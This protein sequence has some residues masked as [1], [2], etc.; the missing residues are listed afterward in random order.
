MKI[1]QLNFGKIKGSYFLSIITEI[2]RNC[3]LMW[4]GIKTITRAFRSCIQEIVRINIKCEIAA[5]PLSLTDYLATNL[6]KYKSHNIGTG[7]QLVG[8][9]CCI[10]YFD[11]I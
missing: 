10:Y 2:L 9:Y 6:K 4:F 1:L 5:I 8:I 11:P 3:Q 7:T